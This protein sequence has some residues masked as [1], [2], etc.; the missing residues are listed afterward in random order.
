[1][2]ALTVIVAMLFSV[3]YIAIE[4][5]H[6]CT[7]ENCL[8]CCQIS[9]CENTLKSI[10]NAVLVVILAAFIGILMLTLP[11]FTKK[12]AFNTSLVT[13]KVKLSD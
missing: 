11:S 10:G 7:G 9:A 13:L 5:D 2:L 1:M 4:A 3:S 6:D 12:M 8:T